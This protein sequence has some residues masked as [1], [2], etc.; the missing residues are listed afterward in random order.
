M[1]PMACSALVELEDLSDG[2]CGPNE[3]LCNGECV[4]ANVNNGCMSPSC[5]PCIFPNSTPYCTDEGVCKMNPFCNG[6]EWGNCNGIE[7]DGC[8]TYLLT[9]PL[10]CGECAEENPEARCAY[11]NAI[12]ACRMG[13]CRF[14]Y[15]DPTTTFLDCN[16]DVSDGCEFDASTGLGCGD[17]CPCAE[18]TECV[19]GECVE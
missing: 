8:E 6:D 17:D 3:K 18:G 13:T 1:A 12:A 2:E 16:D 14:D 4:V 5:D 11:P 10:N 15:C 9:D 7:S 19:D